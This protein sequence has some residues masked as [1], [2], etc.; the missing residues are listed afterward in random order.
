MLKIPYAD[1]KGMQNAL[2]MFS[3][4][5]DNKLDYDMQIKARK[6][7]KT[8]K[9]TRE[10]L[11]YSVGAKTRVTVDDM[12]EFS[13]F[14]YDISGF[15]SMDSQFDAILTEDNKYYA[16]KF[17]IMAIGR[18]VII[19]SPKKERSSTMEIYIV[20]KDCI[21]RL[22]LEYFD[23]HTSAQFQFIYDTMIRAVLEFIGGTVKVEFDSTYSN[24]RYLEE[25]RDKEL[26]EEANLLNKSNWL[27]N[28][29]EPIFA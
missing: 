28:L 1:I 24:T 16:V 14:A 27:K 18:T 6:Y 20:S 25:K 12:Y 8:L 15:M 23:T 17:N 11:R 4:C 22:D 26:L 13:K 7:R 5:Y 2:D 21:D 3:F 9:E 19:L 10:I 29:L